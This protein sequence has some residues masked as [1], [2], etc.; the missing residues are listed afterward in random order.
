MIAAHPV[1]GVG[2]GQFPIA[3]VHYLLRPGLIQNGAFILSTPKVAH[4]TYL[5]ITAELGLVGGALFVA[6]LIFC[7]GCAVLAIKRVTNAG[8]ECM[9]I[10]LRGYVVAVG[11]YLV[12]L[13]FLSEGTAKLLWILLA[14]GPVLLAVATGIERDARQ[15]AGPAVA[16]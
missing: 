11:G 16:P 1:R 7:V 4:N 8:D 14:L 12:T 10:L 9:E 15:R 6:I 13:M 5:N 3:S 2:S